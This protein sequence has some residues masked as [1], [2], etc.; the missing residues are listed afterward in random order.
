MLSGNQDQSSDPKMKL[1][2]AAVGMLSNSQSGGVQG[3]IANLQQSG[4]GDI[5]G[6]WVGSGQNL[7]ISADQIKQALGNGQLQQL[8]DAAGI[9]HDSA[10]SHLAEMLPGIVDHLTPGGAVPEAGAGNTSDLL[11]SL[12]ASF[13]GKNTGA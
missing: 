4:L 13:F 2:Q 8:A 11:T 9:S 7:P 10:A 12:A 3:L 6:S 5:V 1:M